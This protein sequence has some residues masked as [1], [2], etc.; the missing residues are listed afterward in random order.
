MAFAT[1]YFIPTLGILFAAAIIVPNIGTRFE[2]AIY[3]P[4]FGMIFARACA[5]HTAK[6]IPYFGIKY[7]I[8]HNILPYNKL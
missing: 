1:A 6:D 3:M 2:A 5:L 7:A 8:S 4:Y